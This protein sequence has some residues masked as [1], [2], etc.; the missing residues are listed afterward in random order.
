MKTIIDKEAEE[1]EDVLTKGRETYIQGKCI[2]A[3]LKQAIRIKLINQIER[4]L[5]R[6]YAALRR[7]L[8]AFIRDYYAK[9]D[10][11]DETGLFL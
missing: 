2:Q 1:M 10:E 3:L 7:S 4:S 5:S 11:G 9:V 8:A 6:T